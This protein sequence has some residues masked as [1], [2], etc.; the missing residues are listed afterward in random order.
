MGISSAM[1][2]GPS[3]LIQVAALG[4]MLM[5]ALERLDDNEI[6]SEALLADLRDMCQRAA[7]ELGEESADS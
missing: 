4:Q 3:P 6:A 7:A 2:R 5:D 1:R